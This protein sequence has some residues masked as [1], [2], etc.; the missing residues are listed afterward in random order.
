MKLNQWKSWRTRWIFWV[1]KWKSSENWGWA[2]PWGLIIQKVSAKILTR[3]VSRFRTKKW[4]KEGEK[5]WISAIHPFPIFI[6][7]LMYDNLT[8][9]SLLHPSPIVH[10]S[11]HL[12]KRSENSWTK[13]FPNL[14]QQVL[15]LMRHPELH[16]LISL[17]MYSTKKARKTLEDKIFFESYSVN[18]CASMTRYKSW[19]TLFPSEN[20]HSEEPICN[21]TLIM[22][23]SHVSWEVHLLNMYNLTWS[24]SGRSFSKFWIGIQTRMQ[25]FAKKISDNS[26]NAPETG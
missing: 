20:C 14:N 9:A 23:L 25:I 8:L 7:F 15:L 17:S 24:Q 2:H 26:T 4:R 16:S 18:Y 19:S 3:R 5:P 10:N 12:V 6:W 22:P 11:M 21:C 1:K 13:A